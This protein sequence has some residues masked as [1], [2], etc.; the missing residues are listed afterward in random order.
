MSKLD[1]R[2]DPRGR[3]QPAHRSIPERSPEV[4][5]AARE[6]A[7]QAS[8]A[9]ASVIEKRRPA[10]P[11]VASP[12]PD[13]A[14]NEFAAFAACTII[15]ATRGHLKVSSDR[16]DILQ[17]WTRDMQTLQQSPLLMKLIGRKTTDK[18]V[19]ETG[20]P[21]GDPPSGVAEVEIPAPTAATEAFS[22]AS[23]DIPGNDGGLDIPEYLRR[24]AGSATDRGLQHIG[25]VVNQIIK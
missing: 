19:A 8:D 24:K 11:L 9:I 17:V 18:P 5:A 3:K 1:T 23:Q 4:K 21:A 12:Q 15:L 25:D 16:P 22:S 2:T 10:S 7:K 13:P 14:V 20:P 6:S